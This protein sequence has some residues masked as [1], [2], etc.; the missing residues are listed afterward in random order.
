MQ[1][2]FLGILHL[3]YWSKAQGVSVGRYLNI[4]S[5]EDIVALRGITPIVSK[6]VSDDA[7]SPTKSTPSRTLSREASTFNATHTSRKVKINVGG[8]VHEPFASTLKNIPDSPLTCILDENLKNMLDYDQDTGELFFDR[9]PE[10]FSQV[11]DYFQTG[12]LHYPRSV[13]GPMFEEELKFWGIEEQ[14]METCC[15]SDYT[16]H[17]VK[18]ENLK[19]FKPSQGNKETAEAVVDVELGQINN[20][21]LD[22]KHLSKWSSLR[23]RVWQMLDQPSS[24]SA[25]K[26]GKDLDYL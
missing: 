20:P 19:I 7:R 12:K 6:M 14:Q 8:Q 26:V 16:H 4:F 1:G 15:W 24:S 3:V 11:L 25:A 2:S 10:T 5:Y 23:Y 21:N 9:H 22:I 18:Q 13:C 17:R